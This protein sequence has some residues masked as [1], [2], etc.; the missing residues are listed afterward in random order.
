LRQVRFIA[1]KIAAALKIT[2]PFNIQFIARDNVVQVIECNLRASRTFPFISKVCGVNFIDLATRVIMGEPV[3][4]V[5]ASFLELEHVGVKAPQF[6]FTRLEGADPV[7]GVE[8]CSTGEVGCLGGDFEEA[9]LK[10]MLSVG[11]RLPVRSILLST[12]PLKNKVEFLG[13]AQLLR[14]MGIA[15]YATRGTANF[16]REH[17]IEVTLL[18]WPLD[19]R[20]PNALD[21]VVERKVDLVINIPK[22]TEEEEL[23]NDYLIRRKAI[24]CN[25]PLITDFQIAKRFTEAIVHKSLADLEVK[26]WSEYLQDSRGVISSATAPG[27]KRVAAELHPEAAGMAEKP[28][29]LAHAQGG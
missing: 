15:L 8:M 9:F 27:L 21:Y 5:D 24:D 4:P 28:T 17:G 11:Y 18:H 22:N 29:R 23:T 2:G 6:S 19:E 25:I 10:A 1:R 16:L 20:K 26:S 14:S 7:T 13:N 12:G 3:E